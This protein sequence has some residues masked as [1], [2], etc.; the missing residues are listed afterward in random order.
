MAPR[1]CVS[2]GSSLPRTPGSSREC[3]IYRLARKQRQVAQHSSHRADLMDEEYLVSMHGDLR[4]IMVRVGMGGCAM[5][6]QT[7]IN[8]KTVV[9][10]GCPPSRP[11][12]PSSS[13]SASWDPSSA[14]SRWLP[15]RS[16]DPGR[17]Q[18]LRLAFDP[19]GDATTDAPKRNVGHC[20]DRHRHRGQQRPGGGRDQRCCRCSAPLCPPCL[21]RPT[22]AASSPPTA[23]NA[24]TALPVSCSF[25][26]NSRLS[27]LFD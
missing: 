24:R 13:W 10:P 22:S 2:P 11:A 20:G 18:H 4:R 3:Y 16:H 5:I 14:A 12:W 9:G 17:A 27:G 1:E 26:S 21:I 25:A 8:I 19:A 6:G 23:G 7:I 15:G